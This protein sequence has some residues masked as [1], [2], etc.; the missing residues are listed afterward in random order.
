ML[1]KASQEQQVGSSIKAMHRQQLYLSITYNSCSGLPD[2]RFSPF[3][4]NV[5]NEIL[6]LLSLQITEREGILSSVHIP[7]LVKLHVYADDMVQIGSLDTELHCWTV[8]WQ[9]K[10]RTSQQHEQSLQSA[11]LCGWRLFS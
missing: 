1:K 9:Q 3:L 8:K 11:S 10:K 6:I 5:L 4:T 2:I 7:D